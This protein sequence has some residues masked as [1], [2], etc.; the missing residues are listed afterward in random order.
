MFPSTVTVFL[1]IVTFLISVASVVTGVLLVV[2]EIGDV[3]PG[4]IPVANAIG[5]LVATIATASQKA[6]ARF[7]Y[8]V[9]INHSSF[10]KSRGTAQVPPARAL[11]RNACLAVT[12]IIGVLLLAVQ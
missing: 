9:F 10:A 5:A 1:E 3:V 4:V 11:S 7:V 6:S 2:V 8:E 12:L